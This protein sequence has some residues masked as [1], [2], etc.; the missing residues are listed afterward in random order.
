MCFMARTYEL[1]ARA[2]TQEDTRRRIVDAAI[3]LHQTVGPAATT[4]TD[5]ADRAGVG[6][7]TVYRHF[8]DET[9]LLHACSGH[10]YAT[11]PFPD[12]EPWKAV[13]DPEERA[14]V[15]LA[16]AYAYH[17]RTEPMFSRTLVLAHD[18]PAMAPYHDHWREA[19]AVVAAPSRSKAARAAA[20]LALSFATWRALTREGGLSD[21]QAADVA[22]KL[23]R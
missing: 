13:A 16:E 1:K 18:H 23:L 20:L 2:Q 8:P 11:H 3:E 21:S 14:R 6:R 12:V 9:A 7:V 17:R 15:A 5:V 19:A 22:L 4:I 10:Y